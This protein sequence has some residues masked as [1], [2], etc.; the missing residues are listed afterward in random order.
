[1]NL[2]P[3]GRT[4]H[5]AVWTGTEMLVWGGQISGSDY[6]TAGRYDPMSDSWGTT[7]ADGAPSRREV[8]T[9]VWT[10]RSMVV[11][12]GGIPG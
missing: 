2:A 4:R 7:S 10:G 12:G 3:S 8:H 6:Q 1:M 9:A 5:T 11:W